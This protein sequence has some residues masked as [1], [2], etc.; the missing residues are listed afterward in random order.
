M[1]AIEDEK[2][3]LDAINSLVSYISEHLTDARH[4]A[5]AYQDELAKLARLIKSLEA[6]LASLNLL[7]NTW[8]GEVISA[9][10]PN[11]P[12]ES[13]KAVAQILAAAP[14]PM[15]VKAIAEYAHKKGLIASSKGLNGVASIVSNV[16][17][18]Y[19]PRIFVN[20]GWG[21][22]TLAEKQRNGAKLFSPSTG[23]EEG[24]PRPSSEPVP[25]GRLARSQRIVVRGTAGKAEELLPSPSG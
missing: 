22:W 3:A 21:W 13:L 8:P 1:A 12:E 17:S 4:K 15:R 7:K 16:V 24:Q 10:A 19:S 20:T 14:G 23:M 6:R 25:E 5:A 11:T 2:Q 18:R 9:V